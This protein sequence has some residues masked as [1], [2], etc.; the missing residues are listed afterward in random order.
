MCPTN[1]G[2]SREVSLTHQFRLKHSVCALHMHEKLLVSGG[3]DSSVRVWEVGETTEPDPFEVDLHWY[4]SHYV[5]RNPALLYRKGAK[6]G[7]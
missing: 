2:S 6:N 7:G 1:V 3:S 5:S 4:F